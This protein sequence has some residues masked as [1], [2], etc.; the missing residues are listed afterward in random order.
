MGSHARVAMRRWLVLALVGSIV[1]W[2][3]AWGESGIRIQSGPAMLES[4]NPPCNAE[5]VTTFKVTIENTNC[6]C[7]EDVNPIRKANI[8]EARTQDTPNGSF[9]FLGFQKHPSDGL[10]PTLTFI[11]ME[12]ES[13]EDFFFQVK[14]G[15][16]ACTP[17]GGG[18]FEGAEF[19]IVICDSGG[20]CDWGLATDPPDPVCESPKHVPVIQLQA[21]TTLC[22]QTDTG[23][24]RIQ[25]T[26]TD[27]TG[28]GV[29]LA[30]VEAK[31]GCRGSPGFVKVEDRSKALPPAQRGT[32]E[33][34]GLP[35]GTYEMTVEE[36]GRCAAASV[37]IA[38][39]GETKTQNFTLPGV[40][41]ACP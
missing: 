16:V 8:A 6:V 26:V 10:S 1:A 13:S 37:T 11:D 22:P 28:Q 9:Q 34:A 17:G 32:Y 35:A 38:A 40:P 20:G 15:P 2:G 4:S 24:A 36:G 41:S 21:D 23:T 30:R 14:T 5:R 27:T 31:K 19:G 29:V 39:D 12:D 25:G 33:I 7:N 18:D 3:M